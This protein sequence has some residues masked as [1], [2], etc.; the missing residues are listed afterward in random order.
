MS[1]PK[2]QDYERKARL[3]LTISQETKAM[4]ETV[5]QAKNAP[6]SALLEDLIQ[7]EYRK[8]VKAGKAAEGQIPGQI[9]IIPEQESQ[10]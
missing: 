3:N 4:L 6:I 7:R 8:L 5:R 10:R 9:T 2:L 1:R